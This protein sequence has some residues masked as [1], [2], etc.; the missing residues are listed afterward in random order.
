MSFI[1]QAISVLLSPFFIINTPECCMN[2]SEEDRV[3]FGRQLPQPPQ[4]PQPAGYMMQP[5]Y[6]V[7]QTSNQP[8]VNL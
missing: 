6:I 4:Q 2:L 1:L 7:P 5:M 8:Q 3:A